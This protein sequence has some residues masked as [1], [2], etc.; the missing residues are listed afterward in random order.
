MVFNQE[1]DL[2]DLGIKDKFPNTAKSPGKNKPPIEP[3]F[4]KWVEF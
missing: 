2:P 1:V 3:I 4:L